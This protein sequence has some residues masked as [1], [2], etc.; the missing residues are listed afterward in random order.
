MT[1]VSQNLPS[2]RWEGMKGREDYGEMSNIFGWSDVLI[3]LIRS[4]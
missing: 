2:L 1:N 4:S 3:L